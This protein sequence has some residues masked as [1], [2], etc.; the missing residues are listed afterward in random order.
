MKNPRLL[1]WFIILLTLLVAFVNLPKSISL[2]FQIG[3]FWVDKVLRRPQVNF[4]FG[5][6]KLRREIDFKLGLDLAGGAHLVFQAEI[7]GVEEKDRDRAL[8]AAREV[9]E[10]R[11]N[12]YGL[13]EPLIQTAKVGNDYRIIVELAGVKDLD[14]A[15]D[16]IGKTAQLDF[17]E[18]EVFPSQESAQIPWEVLTKSTGLTGKHLV[19]SQVQFD[20]AT[21]NPQVGLE[22]SQ[23]GTK[24]FTEITRRNVGQP[25]AIFLDNQLISAPRVNEVISGGQAV[26]TGNFSVEEAKKLSIQLNAGALPI[27]LKIIEQRSVGATLGQ[28]SVQKS[29]FAG[30][31]GLLLVVIFM[32]VSYGLRG[33]LADFALIIY[34]LL[35][36][37]LFK[38]IPVTLTLAG[39]AGF[40]LSVGM[41]VDA[42]ILIFERTKEEKR[43]GK[44]QAIAQELG[45]SRAWNSIRDS[46][47]SSLITCAI[48]YYFGTGPVRGFALTLALGILVSMFSAI[49]VTRTL[50][51][52]IYARHYR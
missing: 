14:L 9:I 12:F 32:L 1:I 18:A 40:I 36:L 21:G 46:N 23:E 49:I 17:R 34:A 30:M 31:I 20:P 50:L 47:V 5:P 35:V 10:R 45:F 24:L 29:L 37:A 25:V 27:P 39:I 22:F 28:T 41:A 44:N 4:S 8:E 48:L 51:R 26:I 7:G 42:N 2:K 38:L 19:R 33:L 43:W 11:I 15:I 13:A 52:L 16:L 3:K 6:L